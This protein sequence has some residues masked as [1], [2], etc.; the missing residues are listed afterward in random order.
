MTQLQLQE[1]LQK[2]DIQVE[3]DHIM[4][5]AIACANYIE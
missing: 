5:S 2:M 4:S 1:K 3:A